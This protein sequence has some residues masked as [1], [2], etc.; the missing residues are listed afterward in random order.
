M[1]AIKYE[2][3]VL[4][5][6]PYLSVSKH[7]IT[8]AFTVHVACN[9]V[10]P[11][12]SGIVLQ[13]SYASIRALYKILKYNLLIVHWKREPDDLKLPLSFN[14]LIAYLDILW[15]TSANS[16]WNIAI[17]KAHSIQTILFP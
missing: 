17:Y 16:K 12:A 5:S 10:K 15:G 4:I 6:G 1:S 13:T 3:R 2:N 9:S 8:S 7:G 14:A 11:R